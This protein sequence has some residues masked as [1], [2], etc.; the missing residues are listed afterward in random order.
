MM[1]T[2]NTNAHNP[3]YVYD[4]LLFQFIHLKRDRLQADVTATPPGPFAVLLTAG[5]VESPTETIFT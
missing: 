4:Y 1:V 3:F 2:C 5:A